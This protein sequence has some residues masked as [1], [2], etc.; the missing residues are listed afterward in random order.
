MEFRE[1]LD[2][3]FGNDLSS[4]AKAGAS[5][6]RGCRFSASNILDDDYDSYWSTA[7]NVTSASLTVK[8][9]GP[10]TFNRIM[11]Q[12]YIPLG[13]RIAGFN[14]EVLRSDGSWEQI[15]EG[16]TIG[17]KRIIMTDK[18][19]T[20]AIRINIEKSYAC[21]TLNGFGLYLDEIS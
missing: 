4:G 7:D 10:K 5:E 8:L 18:V 11:L 12:E 14:I 20:S 1:A 13:Q 3:I 16:T 15:A 6:T 9:E 2:Q 21:P 17:Y 19:T